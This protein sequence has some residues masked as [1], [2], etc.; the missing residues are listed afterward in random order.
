MAEAELLMEGLYLDGELKKQKA[1]LE[2]LKIK[3]SATKEE[4]LAAEEGYRVLLDALTKHE[5][6]KEAITKQTAIDNVEDAKRK[7]DEQ[8]RLYEDFIKKGKPVSRFKRK[9]FY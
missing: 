6:E 8:T 5:E 4:K 9:G 1:I 2:T 7:F 3:K